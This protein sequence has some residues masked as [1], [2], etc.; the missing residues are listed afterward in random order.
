M[1]RQKEFRQAA[2]EAKNAGELEEAKEYLRVFKG[3]EKLID[4]ARGG[5]PIDMSTIPIAPNKRSSLE[6]SFT[7]VAQEDCTPSDD[8]DVDLNTRLEEQLSKQLIMCR[9]TRD[10]HRAMGDVAGTNRF[11]NLA[12]SVQKDLDFVRLAHRKRLPIP[13]F[14]YE[15][16]QFNV[17]KCNTDLTDNEVEVTI[18]RGINYNVPNPKDV[19]TYVK[20]E[21]PYP[22]VSGFACKFRNNSTRV[23]FSDIYTV[24]VFSRSKKKKILDNTAVQQENRVYI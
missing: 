17:V 7:V 12:L 1:E 21:F 13:K 19:D 3:L 11:E 5:I 15:M 14:H 20:L 24:S 8:A 9:N 16:K 4:T 2:V 10:H 18:A 23:S 22:Q 6:D